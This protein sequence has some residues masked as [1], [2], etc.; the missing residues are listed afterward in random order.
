M[1]IR[2]LTTEDYDQIVELWQRAGLPYK[3]QGRD[4]KEAFE[5]QIAANPDLCI[6]VFEENR[7]TG[8]VI[9]TTDGRKG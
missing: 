7:V 5:A 4:R 3:P 9:A 8:V 1:K 6:G 2:R